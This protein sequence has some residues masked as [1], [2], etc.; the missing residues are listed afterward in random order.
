MFN[1]IDVS[2]ILTL[3]GGIYSIELVTYYHS[4]RVCNVNITLHMT[5][6]KGIYK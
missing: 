3:Q 2:N 6:L 4:Q 1:D 5:S